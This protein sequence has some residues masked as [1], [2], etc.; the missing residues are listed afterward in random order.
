MVF[1]ILLHTFYSAALALI[2]SLISGALNPFVALLSLLLG[3]ILAKY[4]AK[5]LNA[6][7]PE[8][9]FLAFSSGQQGLFEAV[10]F[11]FI[12]YAAYRHFVWLLFPTDHQLATALA[13][14]FG[15]LPLHINF[16]RNIAHGATFPLRNPI[17]ASENLRYPFGSD[18]YSALW[19][20]LGIRLQ[21]HLAFT[22]IALTSVSLV[23][24]RAFAGW[25]GI[26]AFFLSGGISGFAILKGVPIGDFQN[27][28]DWRNLFLSVFV[29]QRGF[30]F[31][32]PACLFLLIG[33]RRFINDR[34]LPLPALNALGFVW[35]ILPFFHLHAFLVVSLLILMC[36]LEGGLSGFERVFISFSQRSF[37]RPL[38]IAFI[39]AALFITYS[40]SSFSGINIIHW[41]WA[42]TAHRGQVTEFLL[43]NF[44]PWLILPF[45]LGLGIFSLAGEFTVEQRR[46]LWIE[47]GTYIILLILFFKLMLAPWDWDN[48]KVLI[49]PY[50]GLARLAW[51]VLDK[52]LGSV[53]R[54]IVGFLLFFSGFISVLWTLQQEPQKGPSVYS[55]SDLAYA[56]GALKNIPQ[57]AVFASGSSHNHALT[58]FGRLRALGYH[59]HLWSHGIQF[60]SQAHDLE[61]LY[62]GADNWLELAHKLGV[63]YIYWG[64]EER[65]EFG[66]GDRPWMSSLAN[67]SPVSNYQIYEI[68]K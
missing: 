10:L 28:L 46:R 19:E 21:A 51:V 4:H 49:W 60:D 30:M 52:R 14:N 68:V 54:P 58:Y 22:G 44:G 1:F 15:D 42:W 61:A 38:A 11:S 12:V 63:N 41:A 32:L 5:S 16:I 34:N 53:G 24:L 47:F 65:R 29:S 25:W 67:V 20:S 17:F 13:T 26:G 43:L 31:A 37:G 66:E 8:W 9:R 48:I 6:A 36:A 57:L 56:E 7:F 40:T 3:S 59:G 39:P 55:T 35:G 18:L 27:G 23:A 33:T 62:K 50:L 64:P 45:L 2:L